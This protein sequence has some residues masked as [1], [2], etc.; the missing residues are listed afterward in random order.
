M[1]Y[2]TDS[3]E[4]SAQDKKLEELFNFWGITL[5][6]APCGVSRSRRLILVESCILDRTV[7]W[8]FDQNAEAC[9]SFGL[10]RLESR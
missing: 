2:D 1:M 4:S 6:Y 7:R 8:T 5:F 10:A 9:R 3:G